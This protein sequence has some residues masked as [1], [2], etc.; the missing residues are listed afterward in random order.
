MEPEAQAEV[1]QE[2]LGHSP[3]LQLARFPDFPR[4]SASGAAAQHTV[5]SMRLLFATKRA[6]DSSQGRL[7]PPHA[8]MVES[9]QAFQ[10]TQ[11]GLS[12]FKWEGE[13]Y[14][15]RTFN[16]Y[17]FPR[18]APGFDRRFLSQARLRRP[19]ISCACATCDC[20]CCRCLSVPLIWTSS[21]C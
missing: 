17:V 8:Q 16:F 15:A 10:I 12:A 1:R 5:R 2:P 18:P 13:R 3:W 20:M 6:A 7:L 21:R 11:F 9:A 14:V 19:C 4:C